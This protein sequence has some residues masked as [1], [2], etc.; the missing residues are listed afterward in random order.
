ME[1]PSRALF[2]H[3][4]HLILGTYVLTLPHYIIFVNNIVN[5]IFVSLWSRH[6]SRRP[7][8]RPNPLSGGRSP[9]QKRFDRNLS[10]GKLDQ[11]SYAA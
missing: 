9:F 8:H 1:I 6:P 5:T 10:G 11:R 2:L 7:S 3:A 4:C